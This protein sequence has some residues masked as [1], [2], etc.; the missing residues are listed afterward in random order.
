MT[1]PWLAWRIQNW[2]V[3]SAAWGNL[4]QSD[5]DWAEWNL[6]DGSERS[7]LQAGSPERYIRDSALIGH[8]SPAHPSLRYVVLLYLS[9]ALV[10]WYKLILYSSIRAS[11]GRPCSQIEACSFLICRWSMR[12]VGIQ[13]YDPRLRISLWVGEQ[14]GGCSKDVLCSQVPLQ[15]PTRIIRPSNGL[16]PYLSLGYPS[17]ATHQG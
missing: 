17:L 13:S 9:D 8:S 3:R 6:P 15:L 16:V 11:L 10:M 14:R 2:P 7:R 1:F 5:S 4:D 12:E